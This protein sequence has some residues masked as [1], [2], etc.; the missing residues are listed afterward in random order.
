MPLGTE[1]GLG[2]AQTIVLDMAGTQIPPQKGAQQPPIFGPCLLWPNGW[3]DQDATGYGGRPRRLGP[4]HIVLD[5]DPQRG[6][7]PRAIFDPCLLCPNGWMDEDATWWGGRPRPHC[8]RWPGPRSSSPHCVRRGPASPKGTQLPI[9]G[10]SVLAKRLDGSRC[11]WYRGRPRP[12]R[13]C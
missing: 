2:P 7:A 8:V 13:Y 5:G 3:M 1:V 10:A 11:N 12:R 6:T 9:F 4:G